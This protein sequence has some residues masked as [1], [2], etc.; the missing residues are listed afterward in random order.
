MPDATPPAGDRDVWLLVAAAAILLGVLAHRLCR[1]R[2]RTTGPRPGR[3]TVD[4]PDR[5]ETR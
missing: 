4:A 1:T 5:Q 3:D 2:T